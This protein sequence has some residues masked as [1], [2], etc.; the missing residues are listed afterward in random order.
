MHEEFAKL[1][2]TL[3]RDSIRR[4]RW[5]LSAVTITSLAIF[6]ICWNLYFS[7][8]RG[9]A[10]AP[11][12]TGK[13]LQ[14]ILKMADSSSVH[15]LLK[16]VSITI[17]DPIRGTSTY[18]TSTV[19]D[20]LG[21]KIE[22]V[23]YLREKLLGNWVES[24][25]VSVPL[26][27][28][29]V[30]VADAAFLG[31]IALFILTVWLF[32]S[33]RRQN[34]IIA[35]SFRMAANY[36]HTAGS[37]RIPNPNSDAAVKKFQ[38]L[39]YIYYAVTATSIFVTA[40]ENDNPKTSIGFLATSEAAIF[41]TRIAYS[42]M[43]YLPALVIAF[44]FLCDILS[45]S[46]IPAPFRISPN[47]LAAQLTGGEVIKCVFIECTAVMLGTAC[48]ILGR[49]CLRYEDANRSVISQAKH[50]LQDAK[51]GEWGDLPPEVI[52]AISRF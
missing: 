29:K 10:L 21:E 25:F 40:T 36:H 8:N 2:G 35:T 30:N 49:Q 33:M 4:S 50:L 51:G 15:E 26:L 3:I 32:Y 13:T 42:A 38:P 39:E 7:W 5:I 12:L 24:Q 31:S 16:P 1:L 9:H 37:N 11:S 41:G 44:V 28:V 47:E 23:R 20:S 22:I 48:F 14:S 43:L 27:G 19:S 45:L 46:F 6:A 52:E 18:W 34:H 17:S